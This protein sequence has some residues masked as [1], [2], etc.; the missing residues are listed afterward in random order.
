MSKRAWTSK[1]TKLLSEYMIKEDATPYK[2]I[3]D[4]HKKEFPSYETYQRKYRDD[5]DF[6]NLVKGCYESMMDKV[7][8]LLR[9][10]AMMSDRDVFIKYS[11]DSRNIE[12]VDKA[13]LFA[14]KR[15]LI[16]IK[17]NE[18]NKLAATLTNKYNPKQVV[19]HTGEISSKQVFILPDYL[20]MAQEQR[21][22]DVPTDSV[23][24]DPE[25]SS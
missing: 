14:F 17:K 25:K 1:H 22:I 4:S 13:E 6:R 18:V 7:H 5:L 2:V 15:N 10:L 20:K 3:H 19:E 24:I 23:D 16:D 21:V 8:T 11:N 12:D 9:E